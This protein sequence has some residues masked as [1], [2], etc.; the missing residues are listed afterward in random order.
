MV[1]LSITFKQ[2]IKIGG[3]TWRV[4]VV[5]EKLF[6]FEFKHG[7]IVKIMS[8]GCDTVRRI[9]SFFVSIAIIFTLVACS[10]SKT[11]EN[12]KILNTVLVERFKTL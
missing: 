4:S 2:H 3:V 1:L 8:N 6:I 5:F 9:I 7:I 12:V 10:N 11:N